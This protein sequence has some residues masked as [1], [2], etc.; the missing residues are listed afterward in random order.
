MTALLRDLRYALRAFAKAPGFTVTVIATLAL[1]I[2]AN[3]AIFSLIN[4]T[5]LSR[6][7]YADPDR[8]AVVR[9]RTGSSDDQ[10]VSYPDF[11]DWRAQ[12]D[13]FSRLAFFRPERARLRT[14]VGA[15][16]VPTCLVSAEFF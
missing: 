7:P 8:L 5:F 15:E 14:S 4:T 9:A 10:Q 11:L 13:V 2:G 1:G 6:L 3:T 12:Q 16:L